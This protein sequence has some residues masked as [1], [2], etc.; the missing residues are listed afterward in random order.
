[1][2]TFAIDVPY[3]LADRSAKARDLS[4]ISVLETDI[5]VDHVLKAQRLEL[6]EHHLHITTAG[7][8]A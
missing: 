4:P 6:G 5:L 3:S 1:M 7:S 8:T 2:S